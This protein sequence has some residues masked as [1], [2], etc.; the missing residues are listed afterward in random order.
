MFETVIVQ[1]SKSGLVFIIVKRGNHVI[2]AWIIKMKCAL[3][4]IF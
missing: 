3:D 1:N 2:L 4:E